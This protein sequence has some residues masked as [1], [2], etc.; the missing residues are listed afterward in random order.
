M[1]KKETDGLEQIITK[2]KISRR[3]FLTGATVA[4]GAAFVGGSPLLLDMGRRANAGTLEDRR[5]YGFNNPESIITSSCLQCNTGCPIKVKSGEGMPLK[6]EG[7]P[8]SPWNLYPHLPYTSGY[9]DTISKVDAA[10]CPKGQAGLQAYYDPYRIRK[11][12]KRVGK[13]GENKWVGISFEQALEEIANGGKLFA[14]V[15]GEEDRVVEGLNQIRA[16]KD[17]KLGKEMSAEI[18]KILAEK[19][20]D[21]KQL[22]V[23][24]FKEKFKEHLDKLIDPDHPDF[25]AKNNQFVFNWGRLK[26]G[27][28]DILKRFTYGG[29]GSTNAHGHTTVCQGSLYFTGKAMSEQWQYD[30]TKNAMS[31]TGGSKFYWQGEYAGAEFIL[32]V[33]ANHFEANY[34]PPLQTS[35]I[36]DGLSS[37]RLKF[38]CVDPRFSKLASKAWKWLPA[39]PGEDAGIAM[40]M[41]R[42]IIEN[43]RYDAK[44]LACAN[45]AAAKAAGEPTWSNGAWLVKIENGKPG[46][47]LRAHEIGG[48]KVKK[49]SAEGL[50]YED[51]LF[52]VFKDG[53]PVMFDPNSETE[54]VTGDLLVDTEI[55]GIKVKSS[56]TILKEE[57]SKK[58]IAEWAEI[59]GVE[60]QEIE[61]LA[62]EF[63]SHGK[64]AVVDIHR[65]PSQHTNGFYNN[66]AWFT[67]NVLN[68]NLDYKGG[69]I[70]ATNYS[71]AGAKEGQVYKVANQPGKL[72]DFGVSLIRHNVKYEDTTIF[73][74]YPAKRP[75]FPLASDVYQEVLP[76]MGD[77]YP[78][79]CKALFLYMGSPIYT[80]PA[81]G[82]LVDIITDVKKVPLFVTFD[83]TVGETS[84]FADYII[85]DLTYLERWEFQ[86]GHPNIPH[87]TQPIR[88][89]AAPP[90]TDNA[91]VYGQEM[92]MSLESFLLGL[93]EKMNLPGFGPDGFEKGVPLTHSDHLYL[94][95]VANVATDGKP[96]PDA[97][98]EEEKIFLAARKHLPKSVFDPERWKE[99]CG[100]ANWKKVVYVLNRGGRFQDDSDTYEGEK[101]KNKYG[102]LVN[103][104]QEKTAKS[105]NTMTGKSF[106]PHAAYVPGPTDCTGKLL[107]DEKDGFPFSLITY[108]PIHHTKSRTAGNYWLLALE[109]ENSLMMNAVDGEK[110]GL[111]DGDKVRLLSATNPDGVW[112]LG[113]QGEIQMVA[114]VK[115][116]QGIRPGTVAFH[117]SFGHFAY[118]SRDITVDGKVIKGDP[119][120]GKGTHFNPVMRVDPVLKNVGLQDIT[121]GS[122][123]FYDTRVKVVKA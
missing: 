38:A 97:S 113:P 86:G 16:V 83:I 57:A 64:K 34:G 6:I 87:K 61:T 15:P 116:V 24:G 103:I 49:T 114:K 45:K 106:I 26:D 66:F 20:K 109:K 112:K 11:V 118:G 18:A 74:G 107:T 36:I 5:E 44:Y 21:K 22:L 29:M 32:F 91:K 111:K 75:W 81:A 46:A 54:A 33:G 73:K 14:N 3:T 96:V 1:S 77:A 10:I 102:T 53:Q 7:S 39:K 70:K 19:D 13:R 121:G 79:P 30:A 88:Q 41:I 122:I 105:K 78:Y 40:G 84:T 76:S 117:V 94:K 108:R 27:R 47:F 99:A 59:A 92:P 2:R 9:K 115:L 23:N 31:W 67:L 55:N 17:A 43:Q 93:A 62:K 50:D 37:G 60:A 90:L 80:L 69:F 12:L 101:L 42:W 71:P 120:R 52:V 119:R 68:G 25:G 104:Y 100:V 63:T 4:T 110:L 65:G 95:Q 98:D 85:P 48:A 82:P 56:L 51:E 28:G 58:T 123:C 89:P 72:P 8:Y 35:R